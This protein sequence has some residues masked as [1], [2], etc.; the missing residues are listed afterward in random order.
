MI[1]SPKSGKSFIKL[2]SVRDELSAFNIRRGLWPAL[3]VFPLSVISGNLR[4]FDHSIVLTGF[5]TDEM[6]FFFLGLGWLA[7]AFTP[8][9]LILLLLRLSAVAAFILALALLY[10]PIGFAQSIFYM[11]FKFFIGLGAASAFYLFCF[12]LN[13]V[14]RLAGM[15][16]IQLYY[17]F[18]YITFRMFPIV[19]EALNTWVSVVGTLVYLL[20]VFFCSE[21][22][23]AKMSL[24]INTDNDGKGSGVPL[25]IGLSIIH[26]TIMCMINYIEWMNNVVSGFA[27]G[28]GIFLSIGLIIIVQL[29]KGKNAMYIWLSFLVL[30]LLGLGALLYDNHFIFITG[31]FAYGLGDSLG[32]II[33]FYLCAGAIKQ[34]KSLK[35]FRLYCVVF[36]FEYFIIS[37]IFS[38]YFNYFD[39]ENISL[40]F[41]VVLVLVSLCFF[42]MPFIQKRLFE[43]DWTD[44]L[45]LRDMGEF[46]F[47]FVET[48]R[49]N[50][51]E[52]LNL[53]VREEEV[54]TMLLQGKAPKEIGYIL[55]V[56]YD[57]VLFHQKKLYR[58]LGIQSRSELFARYSSIQ[59]KKN[60]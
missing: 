31:S 25:V 17:G 48:E 2:L 23:W 58:K 29:L 8:K 19:H 32:Y 56:S 53:T 15:I 30:S 54:F 43:A 14:E 27:F 39:I 22:K 36:F 42:F 38:F 24:E 50:A 57:T 1:F 26:Y 40:A 45:Y 44:G 9:K 33:I 5:A 4:Y 41:G 51:K 12:V 49:L 20:A 55:K 21:K 46:S 47:V 11:A 34:S 28:M 16:F 6:T 52:Q 13:N 7:L 37:R 59:M 10:I 3:L 35:M 60:N 18:Y